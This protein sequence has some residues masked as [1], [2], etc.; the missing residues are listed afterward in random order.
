MKTA[1]E[2]RVLTKEIA[3]LLK[4]ASTEKKL[5]VKGILLGANA[6]GGDDV[7]VESDKEKE[8]V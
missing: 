6:L 5:I 8:V 7:K 3:E 1:N 2:G 4:N